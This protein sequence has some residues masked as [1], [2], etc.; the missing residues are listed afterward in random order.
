MTTRTTDHADPHDYDHQHSDVSG[1]TLRAAA[2]GAMDGLV[3]NISLVAGVGAAGASTHLIILTGMAGLVA[4][5][6]S[7][8]LGEFASVSTSNEQLQAEAETERAALKRNPVG[9]LAELT[10]NF[11]RMGMTKATAERAAQEVHEH[12]ERALRVHITA[13][14]GVNPDQT[15]S[16]WIA[17][18]SSFVMFS[19]GAVVP[20]L[21]Y[22]FGLDLLWVGLV[23]GGAGLVIAGGAAARFTT[24]SIWFSA[25]RQLLFGAIAVTATY[26]V[27]LWLGVGAAG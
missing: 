20:L 26:L 15:P 10:A 18:I 22:F 11:E 4:G 7:M 1:G 8:A 12:P 14:L 16:P 23:V 17:A 6:F 13:E 21:P 19:A 27:G 2:F 25:L 3:T 5:A 9:E 24:K